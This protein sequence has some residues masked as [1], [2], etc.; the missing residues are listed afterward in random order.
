MII[1]FILII[2]L[3]IS[4]PSDEIW[5]KTMKYYRENKMLIFNK[6]HFIFDEFNYTKL[7]INDTKMKTLYKKQDEIY[8]LF[9]VSTFIFLVKHINETEE[10]L[11]VTFRANMRENLKNFGVYINLTLFTVISV[12]TKQ[13]LIYT[14]S[15]TKSYYISNEEAALIKNTLLYNINTTNYYD[16][17]DNFLD[18]IISKS[19]TLT[20]NET[21]PITDNSSDN[22]SGNTILIIVEILISVASVIGF[23]I[24]I[25]CCMKKG[26]CTPKYFNKNK[27]TN[28]AD[29][30]N[31]SSVSGYSVPSAGGNSVG[32]YSAGGNSVGG[33]SA[34]GNSIGGASGGA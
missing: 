21:I 28:N 13:A 2:N 3:I 27:N 23:G 12:D 16:S 25:C 5:N 32:G 34:G 6:K 10:D 1:S 30:V 17:L 14:G 15:K 31:T 18:N 22:D 8:I 33:Y 20:K 29:N 24:G 7:S 11:M 4:L 26:Y 19:K 9:S